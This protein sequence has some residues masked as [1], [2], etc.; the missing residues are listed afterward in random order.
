MKPTEL[1]SAGKLTE[2][3][4]AAVEDVKKAPT[5]LDRRSF[6][7]ELLCVNG[8]LERADAQLDAIAKTTSGASPGLPLL[9]Q[10]VR[11]ERARVEFHSHGRVPELLVTPTPWIELALQASIAIREGRLSEAAK[12]LD[13]AEE[14]RVKPHGKLN[15]KPFDDLRD[16]DDLTA[17]VLEVLTSTG[18]YYWVP[19]E[20]VAALEFEKPARPIDLLWRPAG[21]SVRGGPD[22]RVF[23]AMIYAS[24]AVV[25]DD[26]SRMGRH[27]DWV[28]A[29]GEPVRGLGLRTWLAGEDALTLLEIE[30]LSVDP[31]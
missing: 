26:G 2:A 3:I 21:L 11:A 8:E 23:V 20:N 24:H 19:F 9:R 4:A 25:Q 22:G 14:K 7:A 27:T 5:D 31:V 17:G 28:G 15:G 12:L 29:K 1:Y 10:L 16:C 13:L 6:L 18:K 30:K